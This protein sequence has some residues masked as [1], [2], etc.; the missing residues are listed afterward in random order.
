MMECLAGF[1]LDQD[2]YG[3]HRMTKFLTAADANEQQTARFQIYAE[4]WRYR[5]CWKG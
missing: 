3:E 2:S 4:K 1:E 5:R